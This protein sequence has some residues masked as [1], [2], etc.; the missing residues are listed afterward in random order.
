MFKKALSLGLVSTLILS[1]INI[2][3]V[4]ATPKAE[5]DR[6]RTEKVKAGI[7][8]L[9]VGKEAR[10]VVRLR[11]KTTL[12]GY[13][14]KASDDSFVIT[15]LKTGE[16]T[17]VAYPNVTQVKGHNLSTAVKIAIGAAIGAGVLLLILY[18]VYGR[19]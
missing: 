7:A 16:S 19:D 9:G 18:L 14:S 4:S 8:K 13:I 15:D 3:V 10:V 1:L 6:Q 5:K 17:T 12:S 2:P 11:D